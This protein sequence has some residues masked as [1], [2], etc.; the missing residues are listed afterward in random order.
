VTSSPRP[1]AFPNGLYLILDP[2]LSKFRSLEEIAQAALVAGVRMFQLRMKTPH[3]GEFYH[4]ASRLAALIKA[5]QGYCI[6][7]DR[8]D[9]ALA[10]G[11]DGVH[12]GQADLPLAEARAIVGQNILIGVSTHNLAQAL[13]AQTGGADYIGFGPI[14][15]SS[16]KTNPDPVVGIEGLRDVRARVRLPVVA[17]GGISPKN[18]ADV[19]AAGAHGVAVLSAVLAA[20]DPKSAI[21]ELVR[22]VGR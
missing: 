21:A 20:P 14:F 9:V 16:T 13:D 10:V 22:I 2:A 17:I 6:L 8:C 18:A 7:N 4:M 3:T 12:L 1:A 11:A 15:P 5:A 19:V